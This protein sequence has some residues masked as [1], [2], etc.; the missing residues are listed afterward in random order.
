MLLLS[1][2]T[3]HVDPT[4]RYG[5][6]ESINV[7]QPSDFFLLR[8]AGD[9][10]SERG[11]IL[12]GEFKLA[13]NLE[14]ETRPIPFIAGY[15]QLRLRPFG[16]TDIETER[17]HPINALAQ[18]QLSF[19]AYLDTTETQIL[20]ALFD[21]AG[22]VSMAVHLVYRGLVA[23]I[24]W[25]IRADGPA[26]NN[27]MAASIGEEP[28]TVD[29]I[30]AAFLSLPED[31]ISWRHIGD[32]FDIPEAPADDT[33]RTEAAYHS[34]DRLFEPIDRTD[35]MPPPQYR[36]VPRE[37]ADFDYALFNYRQEEHTHDLEWSISDFFA[38]LSDDQRNRLFP[39]VSQVSPFARVTIH[40][41]NSLSFDP[42]FLTA[43]T[44]DVKNI[45]SQGIFEDRQFRF[46]AGDPQAAQFTTFQPVLTG[47]L[48]LQY[49]ITAVMAPPQPDEWPLVIQRDFTA[50]EGRVIEVNRETAGIDFVHL[51]ADD[52]VFTT[53]STVDIAL[54]QADDAPVAAITLT[55]EKPVTWVALPDV[56]SDTDLHVLCRVLPLADV[57]AEPFILYDNPL[58]GREVAIY[59]YQLDVLDPDEI[60]ATLD[61]TASERYPFVALEIA[62][63]LRTLEPGQAVTWRILRHDVF[64]PLHY[65]YRLH[66]VAREE[67]G[68]TLP[69][70]VSDWYEASGHHHTLDTD[71]IS[72]HLNVL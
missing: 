28:A 4:I 46:R 59:A 67:D 24:P 15:S 25:L 19:Q 42:A 30:V 53:A 66:V 56:T 39:T 57:E 48:Q 27:H 49:R 16:E 23:G 22:V 64:S 37:H 18:G 43:I 9:F 34:V 29:Q 44:V 70:V 14:P 21:D 60:T 2:N 55:K 65:R 51:H 72:E 32:E 63:T 38:S 61:A 31:V 40:L 7:I 8:Y 62:A 6:P 5:L 13:Y 41:I 36:Y 11:G 69:M 1:D 3:D 50:T 68:E 12:R 35:F 58:D 33:M 26:L 47:G 45:G 52:A 17:W 54:T 10:A 71:F 20:Q